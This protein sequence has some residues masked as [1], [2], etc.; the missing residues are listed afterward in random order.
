MWKYFGKRLAEMVITLLALSVIVFVVSR[1]T[2]DPI[3]LLLPPDA[4]PELYET[5]RNKFGLDKP[6]LI[7]Y[8]RFL[9]SCMQGDFGIS[10]WQRAPALKLFFD[11]LPASLILAVTVVIVSFVMSVPVAIAC[12]WKNDWWVDKLV[13]IVTVIGVSFPYFAFGLIMIEIFAVKLHWL[14]VMGM[15]GPKSLIMP[16]IAYSFFYWAEMVRIMRSSLLDVLRSDFI[17]LA[18]AK[19]LSKRQIIGKH[20]LKNVMIPVVTLLGLN[21]PRIVTSAVVIEVVFAWPGVGLLAYQGVFYRDFPVIQAVTMCT[22]AMVIIANLCVD[23][24]YSIIDP[25]IRSH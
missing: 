18:T 17:V 21:L 10:I 6:Y 5:M 7:Q 20:A 19:G 1:L 9:S 15:R 22:G 3:E 16:V 2:G 8:Y 14:P 24:T 25:R 11:R 13:S 4:G 23:L 12:V